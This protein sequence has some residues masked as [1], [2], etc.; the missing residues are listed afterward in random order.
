MQNTTRIQLY[1]IKHYDVRTGSGTLLNCIP[2]GFVFKSTLV[3]GYGG[4]LYRLLLDVARQLL[5]GGY[6]WV[7]AQLSAFQ[8]GLFHL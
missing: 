1:T 2:H 5:D 7:C 3:L 4:I 6:N 8:L